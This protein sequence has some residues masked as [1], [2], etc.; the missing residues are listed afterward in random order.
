MRCPNL[1]IQKVSTLL[2]AAPTCS[3]GPRPVCLCQGLLTQTNNSTAVQA[4][5]S[6]HLSNPRCGL[7]LSQ[8]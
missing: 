8:E 7:A 6:P 1:E 5:S 2:Q 4:L 3:S